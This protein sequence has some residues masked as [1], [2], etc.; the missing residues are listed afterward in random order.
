MRIYYGWYIVAI[1]FV[2]LMLALGATMNSFG[3]FVIPASEDLGL[4]RADT[5]TGIILI[6]LGMA[7]LS[8]F[9]G[10]MLDTYSIRKIMA[11]S[12]V[13]FG[14]SFV[15]IGL[16]HNVWLTG[17][18]LGLPLAIGIAGVSVLPTTTLVARWFV[19]QR[20]RALAITVMGMSLG[21]VV[22]APTVGLLIESVGWRMCLI[23]LGIAMSLVVLLLIPFIRE[24]PG[25]GDLEPGRKDVPAK[26]AEASIS[27]G[28]VPAPPVSAAPLGIGELLRMPVFWMLSLSVAF[29]LAMA[30]TIVVSIVPLGQESGLSVTQSA[31]LLSILGAMA[32]VC[33]LVLAV[34]GD[35]I[36]REL[37]LT[38]LFVFIAATCAALLKGDSYFMLL[39]CSA[40]VGLA[41]GAITPVFMALLA[42]RLGVATF[43][44][45]NGTAGLIMAVFGAIGVRYGGE[46]YDRTG[47]YDVMFTSFIALSL[48]AA[49][50]MFASK[51][52]GA[53]KAAGA[54]A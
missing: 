34:V 24:R 3:M 38:I 18:L 11:A 36:D 19:T 2:I 15:G 27:V 28:E 49:L 13:L 35:W 50:L 47:N 22:M 45:A 29:A 6:N 48:F 54:P 23:V 7:A 44:T 33:K 12:A 51:R 43:G 5:N 30:Q 53:P 25:L 8:P 4:S 17:F 32:I 37:T 14:A 41:V 46:V 52:V 31:S 40:L 26:P 10:R 16:S 9:I 42:D 1:G 39:V 20:G 21:T